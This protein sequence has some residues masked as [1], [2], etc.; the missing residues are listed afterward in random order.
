LLPIIDWT[1]SYTTFRTIVPVGIPWTNSYAKFS[2]RVCVPSKALSDTFLSTIFIKGVVRTDID[3]SSGRII[4]K[5]IDNSPR[6]VVN[7]RSS[8]IISIHRRR[9]RTGEYTF[10]GI[11]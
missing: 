11:V 6:T 10:P 9:G 5:S 8:R 7:A 4:S 3:T 2:A 1:S